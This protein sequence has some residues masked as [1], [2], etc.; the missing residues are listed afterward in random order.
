M[1]L[2]EI[3]NRMSVRQFSDKK[4]PKEALTEILEAGRL[5]PSWMNV[6]PW[7]F[8]IA[9]SDRHKRLL[10]Q[11]ANFQK[12]IAAASH[13]ILILGDFS[14]WNNTNF[15]KILLQKGMSHDSIEHILSDSGYNPA[16]NSN[17][18]LIARTMEQCS[19]AIS[20]MNLQ[21]Q[22]LGIDSCII[23][24]FANELTGFNP[25]ISRKIRTEFEIPD[26]MFIAGMLALGYRK[27][28]LQ[29]SKKIRKNLEDIA[30]YEKYG[31]IELE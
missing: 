22:S 19:Y 15:S 26:D 14:A 23:G 4:I 21:A 7:K 13:V 25:E 30:Y 10:S 3:K 17:A 6:Q 20:F 16:Q 11:C 2:K 27:A 1:I 18:I 28:D 24:A 5:A 29:N 8:I 12:Q 31:R 9:E